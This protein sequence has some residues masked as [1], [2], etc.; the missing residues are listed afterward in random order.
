MK[1]GREILGLL[2]T[3][4]LVVATLALPTGAWAEADHAASSLLLAAPAQRS[5]SCH[6]HGSKTLPDS[7]KSHSPRPAPVS[8][9]C[10]LTGH[11]AAAVRAFFV[12][13]PSG[14][15]TQLDLRVEPAPTTCCL[16]DLEVL[17]VLCADPPGSTPLRI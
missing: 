4:A 16:R 3:A 12:P 6:S 2:L 1:F 7:Q 17:M 15:G 13:Q 8:Y 11:D 10:C 9:Q 14:Q 5:A